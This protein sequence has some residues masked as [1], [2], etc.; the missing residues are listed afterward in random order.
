[1]SRRS[2]APAPGQL[3]LAFD[4]YAMPNDAGVYI[5]CEKITFS[6]KNGR[7]S[8]EIRI[9][10]APFGFCWGISVMFSNGGFAHMPNES[11][12]K[13]GEFAL[14]RMDA[15]RRACASLLRRIGD[16]YDGATT[17]EVAIVGGWAK[18]LCA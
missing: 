1:M 15:L 4:A 9:A 5:D 6:G 2:V 14:T 16:E 8:A 3:A 12:F 7:P 13:S 18:E 17:K 10:S 11:D